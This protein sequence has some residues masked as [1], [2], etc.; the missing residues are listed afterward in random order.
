M[1]IAYLSR[2]GRWGGRHIVALATGAL[3]ARAIDGFF[4]VPL[5]EV[6]PLA[7]YAHNIVFFVGAALLGV[8]AVSRNRPS[9]DAAR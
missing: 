2:S 9:Q 6:P 1:S 3:L 4:A 5:G 7:K 8:W